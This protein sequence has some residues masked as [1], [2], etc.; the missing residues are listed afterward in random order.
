MKTAGVA[1]DKWKL[2]IF[3]RHLDKAG[4]KYTEHPGLTAGTLLLKVEYAWVATLKPVIE[5]AEAECAKSKG[6]KK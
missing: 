6:D 1:I 2:P 4:Y 5:A 3:K